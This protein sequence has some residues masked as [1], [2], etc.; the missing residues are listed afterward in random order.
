LIRGGG[1]ITENDLLEGMKIRPALPNNYKFLP[2]HRIYMLRVGVDGDMRLCGCRFD[3]FSDVDEFHIGNM[4]TM[5]LRQA[6]NSDKAKSL[7]FSFLNSAI[8][9]SFMLKL[10]QQCSWYELPA[11]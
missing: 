9:S 6:F 2:C 1:S 8:S 7:V 5:K 11:M 3:P 4:Q 10:C